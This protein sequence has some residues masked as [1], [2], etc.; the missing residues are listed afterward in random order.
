MPAASKIDA[1]NRLFPVIAISSQSS[2]RDIKL[3]RMVVFGSRAREI[4]CFVT[5]QSERTAAEKNKFLFQSQI[6]DTA[7]AEG[8][9]VHFLRK[10][11]GP[12]C[13]AVIA[14]TNLFIGNRGRRTARS[15]RAAAGAGVR[16]GGRRRPR[17]WPGRD[18]RPPGCGE[19]GQ[20]NGRGP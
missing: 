3:Y 1:L 13:L 20:L 18:G 16:P 14:T 6:R 5:F 4:S 7:D 19:C 2:G 17:R 8:M 12:N 9:Q 11:F 15:Y 10:L